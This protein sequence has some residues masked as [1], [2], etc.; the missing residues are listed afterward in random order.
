MELVWET[1]N[2]YLSLELLHKTERER[3][4]KRPS[5]KHEM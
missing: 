2:P 3:N 5:N 1:K 4:I